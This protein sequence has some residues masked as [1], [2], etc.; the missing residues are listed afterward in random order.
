DGF[1]PEQIEEL[2]SFTAE[3]KDYDDK[4]KSSMDAQ[5]LLDSIAAMPEVE[6]KEADGSE[7]SLG[8]HFVKGA[9]GQLNEFK[10]KRGMNIVVPEFKAAT[11]T[12]LTTT[13]GSGIIIPEYDFD[14][15]TGKR[16]RPF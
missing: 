16:Q 12:H 3:I 13:T 8:R 6:K 1:T 4:I 2:K 15:V 7:I 9:F 11:D 5:S 14:I 10:G